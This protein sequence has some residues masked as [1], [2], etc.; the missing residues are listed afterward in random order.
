MIEL[1][2]RQLLRMAAAAPLAPL[3]ARAGLVQYHGALDIAMFVN[4]PC[5]AVG[6]DGQPAGPVRVTRSWMGPVCHSDVRNTGR[7]P[8]AI[9]HVVLFDV[10]H[11]ACPLR[12]LCT[13]KA[14]RC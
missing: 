1:S 3:L 9:K 5:R 6:L 12:P 2:R 14:F 8:V 11:T 4:A 13:V 10:A 7:V